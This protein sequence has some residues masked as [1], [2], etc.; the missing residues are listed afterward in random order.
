MSNIGE[1]AT[2]WVVDARPEDYI[3]MLASPSCEGQTF[4]FFHTASAALR[5]AHEVQP[6]LWLINMDLPD[7]GGVELCE[8]LQSRFSDVPMYLVRDEYDVEAELAARRSGATMFLC[9]PAASQWIA[10]DGVEGDA[11]GVDE[12]AVKES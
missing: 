2:I 10:G 7:R 5:A 6:D 4:R 1:A 12:F 3:A 11:L 9:K 8:M